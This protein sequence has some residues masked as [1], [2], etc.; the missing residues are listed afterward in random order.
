MTLVVTPA[1]RMAGPT[2]GNEVTLRDG[3]VI[4]ARL[5]YSPGV[6]PDFG[7]LFNLKLLNRRD[8]SPGVLVSLP[9]P[10]LVSRPWRDWRLSQFGNNT[11]SKEV[12]IYAAE[13]A[14]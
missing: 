9:A 2:I 5:A 4:P 11:S 1:G 3:V 8:H 7:P 12:F 6:M 10:L 14:P 13:Q